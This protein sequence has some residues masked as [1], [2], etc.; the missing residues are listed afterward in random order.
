[1]RSSWPATKAEY[2]QHM[3]ASHRVVTATHP[4][5]Q[6]KDPP[7]G[8]LLSGYQSVASQWTIL[9][10]VYPGSF[11]GQDLLQDAP[12]HPKGLSGQCGGLSTDTPLPHAVGFSR[13]PESG[14]AQCLSQNLT[15]SNT[16]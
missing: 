6:H 10:G 7:C 9:T 11:A 15:L 12:G 13:D 14:R 5:Q 3:V 4:G 8:Q 1:M 16:G 2:Q